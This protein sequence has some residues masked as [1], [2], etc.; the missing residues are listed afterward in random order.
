MFEPHNEGHHPPFHWPLQSKAGRILDHH[1]HEFGLCGTI[2]KTRFGSWP[3]KR[4]DPRKTGK[5][6]MSLGENKS[7]EEKD[8]PKSAERSSRHIESHYQVT[9][10]LRDKNN[11]YHVDGLA[12]SPRPR[13]P[14]HHVIAFIEA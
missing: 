8:R 12:P 3:T 4:R 6:N 13:S 10:T 5:C 7:V 2:T 1:N 11:S 14:P 9:S